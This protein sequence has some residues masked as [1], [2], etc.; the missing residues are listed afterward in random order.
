MNYIF[1]SVGGFIIYN[2]SVEYLKNLSR[3]FSVLA[4]LISSLTTCPTVQPLSLQH[5]IVAEMI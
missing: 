5:L 3:Q 2:L 1:S 4:K